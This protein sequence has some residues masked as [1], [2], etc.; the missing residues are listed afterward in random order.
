[1][2]NWFIERNPL[3]ISL[4]HPFILPSHTQFTFYCK[5]KI[6]GIKNTLLFIF[7]VYV[8]HLNLI[9]KTYFSRSFIL[10]WCNFFFFL[11]CTYTYEKH[12]LYFKQRIKYRISYN[13][14]LFEKR[15]IQLYLMRMLKFEDFS[16]LC[17]VSI[18]TFIYSSYRKVV[19]L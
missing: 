6:G 11:F 1:M 5:I 7:K 4:S 19:V 3:I 16:Y 2:N 13:L 18:Y 9:G 10:V 15:N 12:V 14:Q 17:C 8:K